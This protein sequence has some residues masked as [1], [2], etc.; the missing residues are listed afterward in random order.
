[1]GVVVENNVYYLRYLV[2]FVRRSIHVEHRYRAEEALSVDPAGL[3]KVIVDEVA[4]CSIVKQGLNRVDFSGV[5]CKNFYKQDE[6]Y[7][8]SIQYTCRELFG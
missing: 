3:D 6:R 7:S 5:C 2:Y 4:H 1:M 8:A